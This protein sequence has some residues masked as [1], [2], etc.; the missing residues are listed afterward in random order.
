VFV[1]RQEK[2]SFR[3]IRPSRRKEKVQF[4][5]FTVGTLVKAVFVQASN[6]VS[7]KVE[8]GKS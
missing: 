1:L 2:K 8:N 5:Q 3:E 7:I 4:N 6:A